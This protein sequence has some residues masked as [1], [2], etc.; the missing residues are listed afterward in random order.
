MSEAR[1]R[2]GVEPSLP[3]NAAQGANRDL[4]MHGNDDNAQP[5]LA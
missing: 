1:K 2:L 5:F 4:A 3:K